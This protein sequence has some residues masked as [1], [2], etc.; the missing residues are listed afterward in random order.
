MEASSSRETNR[1]VLVVPLREGA[2]E[3]ALELLA[4]GPPFDP[5]SAA[6]VRHDVYVTPREVV[7]VF[8][9]PA[10]TPIALPGEDASLWR[11]ANAW[12]KVMAGPARKARTA[13]S[14]QRDANRP[15]RV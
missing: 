11:A 5:E 9:S 7:F 14:W 3:R 10:G 6:L 1:L 2:Y 15:D 8:E 4:D 12:R 13:C